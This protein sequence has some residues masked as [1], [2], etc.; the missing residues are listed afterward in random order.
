MLKLSLL[1][2]VTTADCAAR[3]ARASNRDFTSVNRPPSL[4]TGEPT[5]VR[6]RPSAAQYT[7]QE[8]GWSIAQEHRNTGKMLFSAV[9]SGTLFLFKKVGNAGLLNVDPASGGVGIVTD[10]GVRGLGFKSSGSILTSR[11]ETSYFQEWSGMVD[12]HALYR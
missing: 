10:C 4:A 2:A 8:S 1:L 3:G 9:R 12:T 5:L 11:T 6:P 7:F